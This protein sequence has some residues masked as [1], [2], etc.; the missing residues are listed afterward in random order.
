MN[1]LEGKVAVVTGGGKGIGAAVAKRLAADGA[2]VV[3]NYASSEGDAQKTV[4]AIS[5]AGG[6]ATAVQANVADRGQVTAL[7]AAARTAYGPVD[8]LINNAGVYEFRPLSA[9]DEEHID[10]QFAINVK[11]LVFASQEAARDFDG[12][13]GGVIIN[14]GSI[15]SLMPPANGSIYA[16]TKAA[17]DAITQSLAKELGPKN[18]RV[19]AVAPGVVTTEGFHSMAGHEGMTELALA[20]T[21]LGRTGL[22]EDIADAVS[23]LVS[24]DSRWITGSVIAVG[25]GLTI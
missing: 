18:V 20:R 13:R 7:F 10:R 23:A 21:P 1:R 6:K 5:A 24:S 4:D 15:V 3:V 12:G 19:V 17:V 2:S 8:I 11:G 25:G 22:P 14:I 16:A 9:I